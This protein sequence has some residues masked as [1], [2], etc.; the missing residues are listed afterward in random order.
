MAVFYEQEGKQVRAPLFGL[1]FLL[2]PG[3]TVMGAGVS[4]GQAHLS[5]AVG[6]GPGKNAGTLRIAPEDGKQYSRFFRDPEELKKSYPHR[7][8]LPFGEVFVGTGIWGPRV[9][10]QRNRLI[11]EFECTKRDSDVHRAAQKLLETL[12]FFSPRAERLPPSLKVFRYL[13]PGVKLSDA[14]KPP[15]MAQAE[16]RDRLS[17]DE[18]SRERDAPGMPRVPRAERWARQG[19]A[20]GP[21]KCGVLRAALGEFDEARRAIA[22]A[23]PILEETTFS[24]PQDSDLYMPALHA[25]I[26]A[27]DREGA[28]R[29]ARRRADLSEIPKV[30]LVRACYERALPLLVDGQ[31]DEARPAVE[32]AKAVNPKKA[33]YRG[34]GALMG[35]ILDRDAAAYARGLEEVLSSHHAYACRKSSH[36]RN[37]WNSFVC[38]PAT[39]LAIVAA[40]RGLP[41]PTD[42]PS[43]RKTLK[44][45]NVIG[46]T[47]FEGR[48]L[49]QGTTFDLEVEY[50]PE[51]LVRAAASS[52]SA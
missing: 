14:P 45:L 34:L 25:A 17:H 48:P 27:G 38:V 33:W 4:M 8:A 44:N 7:V 32:E 3:W 21:F 20:M 26:L 9:L 2:P 35:S 15:G 49:E 47:E 37:S 51:A 1:S 50:I 18:K 40:W 43:R 31:D 39:A 13:Y 22:E 5:F 46:I 41:L 30:I 24:N 28:L 42:L 12:C 36:I 6:D 11:F 23:A 16:L 52:T 29:V 10:F 19:W